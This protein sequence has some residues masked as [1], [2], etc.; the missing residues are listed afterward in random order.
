V[1]NLSI[2]LDKTLVCFLL[3]VF[4]IFVE[5]QL[6][7]G[8]YSDIQTTPTRALLQDVVAIAT[9]D[10]HSL[11]LTCDG[12]VYAVGQNEKGQ[13]GQGDYDNR[14][15]PERV[16]FFDSLHVVSIAGG[17]DISLAITGKCI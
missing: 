5:G 3:I 10:F 1:K 8:H 4:N 14:C 17:A 12:L 6:G 16:S 9:G 7:L 11:Y 13:L 15:V 2:H